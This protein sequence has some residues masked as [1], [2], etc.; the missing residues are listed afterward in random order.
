MRWTNRK[1]LWFFVSLVVVASDQLS[2]Q[3]MLHHLDPYQPLP[4]LPILNLTLAFNTGVAFSLFN[5]AGAWHH[6]FLLGLNGCICVAL[7]AWMLRRAL[8][9]PWQLAGLSLILGGALGNVI[10][11]ALFGHVIDFIQV[12]YKSF[13]W[14]VFNLADS[15][16]SV[17]AVFFVLGQ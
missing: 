12:H 17:G 2:K 11:R 14:P 8:I 16:I 6:W 7:A 15:A 1:W 10:D 3:W 5:Q 13:Q 4:L 9:S